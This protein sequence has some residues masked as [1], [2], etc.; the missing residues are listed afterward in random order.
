MQ[1]NWEKLQAKLKQPPARKNTGNRRR[2]QKHAKESGPAVEMPRRRSEAPAAQHPQCPAWQGRVSNPGIPDTAGGSGFSG[3][4]ADE[5][6]RVAHNKLKDKPV[7]PRK[8]GP[9]SKGGRR[10][11]KLSK[12]DK[13]KTAGAQLKRKIR[14]R[15]S[16]H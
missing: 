5:A 6:W 10:G 1:S 15:K 9:S 8:K 2:K 4:A 16:A 3:G 7:E 14:K 13:R 11:G 12:G